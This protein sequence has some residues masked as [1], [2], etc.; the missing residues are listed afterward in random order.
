MKIRP[1][2]VAWFRADRQMDMTRLN[3]AFCAPREKQK[4]ELVSKYVS[5]FIKRYTSHTLLT[6][7]S[8]VQ[9]LSLV[10]STML[11]RHLMYNGLL[12]FGIA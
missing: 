3:V 6:A 12:Q 1:V 11:L 2:G 8:S 10:L 9:S 4:K 7:Q 5:S